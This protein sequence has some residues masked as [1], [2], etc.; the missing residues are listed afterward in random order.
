M[1]VESPEISQSRFPPRAPRCSPSAASFA[2]LSPGARAAESMSVVDAIY[3]RMRDDTEAVAEKKG[4]SELAKFYAGLQL[5]VTGASDLVGKCLLE[6]LL[7]D[8]PDLE[9]IYVLVRTKKAEEFQAKCDELCDDSVFDLLRKSRPDFRSKLSL[10]RGD[11]AQDGLG[12]SEEDYRSLSENANVIFHNGAATRLDEQVS[13]AL[14]TNVLGTRRMLELA[15]DCK[16]LKAFLLVSSGFAHCQQRVLEEKFYRSP[17][18]LKTVADMLEADAAPSGLT[19]DALEML[20]GEW[21][22]IFAYSKATAEELVRQHAARSPFACCVFRPSAVVSSHKE[23]QPGFVDGKNGPARFFL[24]IAM[25]AV[26]VIY[27]VDYPIDLVPADLSVNAMLVCAWDA[28]DR[29]QVEPGAFVYNF[30]TSQERPI[31]M[32]QIKE[33]IMDDP[34]AL[35]S[36]KSR[37]RPYVL[38]ATNFLLYLAMRLL[39]DYVPALVA[40][41]LAVLHGNAPDSWA[42]LRESMGDMCRLHRFSSGNWRIRMPEMLKA[43]ERLNPRDRELFPCDVRRLDWDDY[44]LTFWRGIR[45]NVLKESYELGEPGGKWPCKCPCK[46]VCYGLGLVLALLAYYLISGLL[47]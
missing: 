45:V 25:G 41:L 8:C 29:W 2:C 15:R 33:K 46:C 16:Q 24:K 44:F 19:K 5:F 20:L 12:L 21:P 47:F 4:E 39:L 35:V 30:G 37:R 14:Q 3:Q 43:C 23:P 40:D 7:R 31:T 9:R 10:L 36:A 34:G 38:F 1:L 27:S 26:H 6:K 22:N 28:V 42:L 18:D 13:L 11:L 32:R 17:A